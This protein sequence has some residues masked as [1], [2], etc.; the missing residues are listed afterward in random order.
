MYKIDV[1]IQ[2]DVSFLI[3]EDD[4]CKQAPLLPL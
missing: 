3:W 4:L 1:K 2:K